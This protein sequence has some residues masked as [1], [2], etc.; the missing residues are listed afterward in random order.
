MQA[1]CALVMLVWAALLRNGWLL[2]AATA[3]IVYSA[4]I[5]EWDESQDM[6]K[7]FGAGWTHYRSSVR[8]WRPRWYPFH[9]GSPAR[10]YIAAT[11][12][13]CS[14]LRAWI[15]KRKPIGMTMIDAETCVRGSIRRLRYDPGDGSGAVDGI[16]ALGRSLEH[17]SLGWAL[18]GAALRI[19]LVCQTVQLVMDASG[20]G[21]R[22][23]QQ[24]QE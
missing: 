8:N 18:A 1:S 12:G 24:V 2:T 15:E 22:E 17:L 11:C 23:L 20:L 13:P 4:G 16:R 5:A 21:P 3:S 7:R 6:E 10:L 14:E 9:M 19:P